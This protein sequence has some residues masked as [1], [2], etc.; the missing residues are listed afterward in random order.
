MKNLGKINQILL[1]LLIAFALLY[2]GAS[3]L[4][5]L[6]FGFFFAALMAPFSNLMEKIWNNRIVSSSVSTLVVLIVVGGVLYIFIWQISLFVTDLSTVRNDIQNLIAEFQDRVMAITNLSIEEQNNIWQ[7]RSNNL[8]DT[9]ESGLTSFLRNVANTTAG[10]FLVLVYVFLLLYY[11][12]RFPR[13]ILMYVKKQNKEEAKEVLNGISKVVYHYLWG[14]TK[15]MTILGIMYYI[16]FMIFDLP[17]AVLLTIFGALVTIIPYLGPFIS[18]LIPIIFS[19]IYL[20]NVQTA[21]FFSII[22]IIV[23]IIESYVL[24]P[25]IIGNEVKVNPLIVII[26]IVV[27][28]A[29]WG[30]AGMILFVP[31]FAMIKI[32]SDHTTGLKPIG[33]LFEYTGK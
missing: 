10:F 22:I 5:P 11:R 17:Y 4:I 27:G 29:I 3:F 26:A 21:I 1:L 24:E 31:V 16:T 18:G 6:I 20:E 2:A 28:E 23:Q 13:F 25:L 8:F 33:Y 9:F 12:D 30:I 15:V 32:I 19:F 7:N 14:R